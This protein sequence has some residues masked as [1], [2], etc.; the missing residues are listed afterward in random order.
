MYHRP[1][2]SNGWH[3]RAGSLLFFALAVAI[4]LSGALLELLH[5]APRLHIS[6]GTLLLLALLWVLAA[7]AALHEKLS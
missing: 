2:K 6:S 5:Y 7:A 1:D 4:L 3:G